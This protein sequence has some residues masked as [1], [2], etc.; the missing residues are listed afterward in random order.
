MSAGSLFTFQLRGCDQPAD[1][2][3]D[4]DYDTGSCKAGRPTDNGFLHCAVAY[5]TDGKQEQIFVG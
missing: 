4:P 5:W 3:D 2:P 1:E